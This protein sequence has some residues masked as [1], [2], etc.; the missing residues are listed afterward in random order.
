M[1]S[2]FSEPS[3]KQK[4]ELLLEIIETLPIKKEEKDLYIFSMD[5]LDDEDFNTFF[6]KITKDVG[7]FARKEFL[8]SPI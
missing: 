8:F 7:S 2:F 3:R 1:L 5:I 4:K 6:I